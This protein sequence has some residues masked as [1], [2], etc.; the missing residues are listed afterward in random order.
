MARVG[1]NEHFNPPSILKRLILAIKLGALV[2]MLAVAAL[3]WDGLSDRPGPADVAL[4]LGTTVHP[5][6]TPSPRSS[7][8]K[9]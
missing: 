5:D 2:L 6:G 8:K 4:V 7:L 9:E 3:V 1:R